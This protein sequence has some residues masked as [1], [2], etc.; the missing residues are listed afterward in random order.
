ML[1]CVCLGQLE[2]G[3]LPGS[4]SA[5]EG[6]TSASQVSTPLLQ[7]LQPFYTTPSCCLETYLWAVGTQGL[8]SVATASHQAKQTL[9]WSWFLSEQNIYRPATNALLFGSQF[10]DLCDVRWYLQ[11]QTQRE[12]FH[13]CVDIT[14]FLIHFCPTSCMDHT[15]HLKNIVS[16]FFIKK[17]KRFHQCI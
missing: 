16:V 10:H 5:V 15:H 8:F 14:S 6:D 9:K 1:D 4:V 11:Q 3:I 13:S 2:C 7:L 17:K 12:V